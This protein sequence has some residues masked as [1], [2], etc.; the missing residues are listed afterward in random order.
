VG[1]KATVIELSSTKEVCA[2]AATAFV[3]RQIALRA[4]AYAPGIHEHVFRELERRDLGADVEGVARWF[5]GSGAEL[6]RLGYRL[7]G[8]RIAFR[9][10]MIAGWVE[11]GEGY[12]G[13]VLNTCGSV[14]DERVGEEARHAVGLAVVPGDEGEALTLLDPWPGTNH[15]RRPDGKLEPAHRERKYAALMIY[16]AGYS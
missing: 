8:R 14:L 4:G 1:D 9:T 13:A 2:G 11:R 7:C 16:W 6:H 3:C 12:R 5:S 15:R 10:P